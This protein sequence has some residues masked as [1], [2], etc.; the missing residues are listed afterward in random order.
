MHLDNKQISLGK[1]QISVSLD[2]AGFYDEQVVGSQ[3]ECFLGVFEKKFKLLFNL[4]I[5]RM[6]F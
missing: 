5:F 4:K 1:F 2:Q 6:I 3:P